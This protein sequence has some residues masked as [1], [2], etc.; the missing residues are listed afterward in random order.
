MAK[1]RLLVLAWT[2]HFFGKNYLDDRIVIIPT[3]QDIEM[4]FTQDRS[5]LTEADAVWFHG[6]SIVDLPPQKSQPWILMSMESDEN[7]PSLKN[8]M[9]LLKFE[10][11]M[12][13]RLDSDVPCIYP[14][15]RD[16]GSFLEKPSQHHGPA[17]GALAV[18]IA[19]NP[20][21]QRDAYAAELMQ[22]V[23]VDSLG[24]CLHNK[25][26]EGFVGNGWSKGAWD[27]LMSVLPRYKF[28]LAFENSVA[29][30]YVT[31][32][33]FHALAAGT[34]PIYLG[35]GNV[36]D[37]MPDK[38][39]IIDASDY[40]SPRELADYILE[41]DQNDVAYE[42]HRAWKHEGTTAGFKKLVDL[43]SIEPMDR[44]AIKLAHGCV[45][46]CRCGGRLREPG[47]IP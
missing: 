47:L 16:Y 30:D 23:R 21:A 1:Q 33:V 29:T 6:P 3:G 24:S 10:I 26:I 27:S 25:D 40:S 34:V 8:K 37:F 31:E 18:Y 45:R 12:T 32:R 19:S 36:R 14:N 44:L 7:Y 13:Y 11:Q 15:W 9:M 2:D 5:R 41:L 22:H 46:S 4:V 28:Y 43:G 39:A 42:R 17:E 38:N 20:A 35:A